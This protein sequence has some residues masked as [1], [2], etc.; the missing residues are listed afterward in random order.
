MA[1]SERYAARL[2]SYT[3]GKDPLAMQ[4]NAP[5]LLAKLIEGV[6]DEALRVKPAPG[7]WSVVEILA[8]LADDEIVTSWRYRQM[9]ENSG[10][11][12]SG[13]DQDEWAR[14]GKYESKDPGQCLRLFRLLRE[15]NLQMLR[16]LSSEE[17]QR[18][19]M[20]AERGR[21][22]VQDLARHMAGHDMNHIDQIRRILE[23]SHERGATDAGPPFY[24][25]L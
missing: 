12:L 7:K 23:K 16:H 5:E 11:A 17:W 20:H 15:S 22:S 6:S 8:H 13:F 2:R 21:M 24:S 14:M 9:L 10:C 3:E 25:A 4:E 18:H 19:G 1:D